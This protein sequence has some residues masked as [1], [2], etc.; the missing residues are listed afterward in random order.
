MLN[1][2]C[3]KFSIFIVRWLAMAFLGYRVSG[4]NN[5]PRTGGGIIAA[6]HQ[7]FL[8]PPLIGSSISRPVYFLAKQELFTANR[9]FGLVLR[10]HNAVPLNRD[11]T[12]ADI[13][14]KAISLLKEGK[15]VIVFPEGTRTYDGKVGEFKGGVVLLSAKSNTPIIPTYING[16]YRVWPR[17]SSL[18]VRLSPVTLIYTKPVWPDTCLRPAQQDRQIAND[19]DGILKK[20][21][22]QIT[23][24]ENAN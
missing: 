3:C 5:I 21:R 14:R 24:L 1:T 22:A 11:A 19:S 12:S 16:S 13:M 17:Q 2:I 6:N 7:S 10:L 4:Q 23:D 9:L 15:L 20:V 8:D 18:P